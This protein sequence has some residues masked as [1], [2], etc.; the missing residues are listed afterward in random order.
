MSLHIRMQAN[1]FFDA[2][3]VLEK[4]YNTASLTIMAPSIVCL[5]F[6]VELYLKDLHFTISGEAP[7]GHDIYK[8]FEK[9]PSQIKQEI[10]AH[11]SISQNPF[12]SRGNILSPQYYNRDY[13]A[14]ERFI[15]QMKAISDGFEKWRY[16]YEVGTLNYD[17]SFAA[18]FTEA[19]ISTAD[20]I[21]WNRQ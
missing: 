18:A 3:K 15:D 19:V 13:S 12:M 2:Y 9:L 5:A 6:A 21:R 1:D 14:Y 10:F 11:K 8:L 4:N 16:S 7:H 20:N 17:S